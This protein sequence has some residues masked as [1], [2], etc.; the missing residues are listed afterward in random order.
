MAQKKLGLSPL[1]VAVMNL[2]MG[3]GRKNYGEIGFLASSMFK[4]KI[5]EELYRPRFLALCGKGI[6]SNDGWDDLRDGIKMRPII[7]TQK[8]AACIADIGKAETEGRDWEAWRWHSMFD[9]FENYAKNPHKLDQFMD[10]KVQMVGR[11]DEEQAELNDR[12]HQQLADEAM[13]RGNQNQL[14]FD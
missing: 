14:L 5:P 4:W 2:T 8:G 7:I 13:G 9:P 12:I 10:H 1:E 3:G 6:V 11:T